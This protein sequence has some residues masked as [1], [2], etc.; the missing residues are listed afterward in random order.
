MEFE[1][2]VYISVAPW[3]SVGT[4]PSYCKAV[5]LM[6]MM[7]YNDICFCFFLFVSFRSCSLSPISTQPTFLLF[8]SN[9]FVLPNSVPSLTPS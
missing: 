8:F 5:G 2:V 7:L 1:P 3:N 6:I 9:L 4:R